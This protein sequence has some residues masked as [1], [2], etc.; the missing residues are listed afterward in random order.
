MV[1]QQWQRKSSGHQNKHCQDREEGGGR[2]L[3]VSYSGGRLAALYTE[4]RLAVSYMKE[5]GAASHIE[6]PGSLQKLCLYSLGRLH[7]TMQLH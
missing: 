2:W 4:E 3:A 1:T 5:R 6:E 7:T